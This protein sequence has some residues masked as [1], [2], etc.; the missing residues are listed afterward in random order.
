M[1]K[2]Y[3]QDARPRDE[4]LTL[5]QLLTLNDKRHFQDDIAREANCSP[6]TVARRVEIVERHLGKNAYIERGIEDRRR[7]YRVRT[8]AGKMALGY[9]F[10]ELHYLA[11]CRDI[12]G[13]A[14][15]SDVSD[16]II[17]SIATLALHL[18]ENNGKHLS[19]QVPISLHNKGFI[20][21]C[22]HVGTIATI[23]EA[24]VKRQVCRVT[25]RAS[26]RADAAEYRYAPGRIIAMNGTLYVQG[27]RLAEGSLLK[28]RTTVFSVHRIGEVSRTGEYFGF[29]AADVGQ[30]GFGL[31]WHAPK[32][33]HIEIAPAAAD[34]VRD[35]I[36]SGDQTIH[37]QAN[38]GVV[39]GV[40][41][42]SEKEVNAWVSSFGGLA[43]II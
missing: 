18:G 30:Q 20:D 7:Y 40:T 39:L 37:E 3:N 28:Y 42:T 22:P 1:P 38:G 4:L 26:G 15:G 6:Q 13:A 25:Y 2:K 11:S 43:K 35:R 24:I 10:E 17:R 41:T 23:R 33:V 19:G 12:A 34:Y 21:Y 32:R 14:L 5:Y 16:R 27:C 36:W 8:T 29:D 9:E 31:N